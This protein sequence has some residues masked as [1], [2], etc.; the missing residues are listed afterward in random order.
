[1][2]PV[3]R[4]SALVLAGLVAAS[5]VAPAATPAATAAA[6]PAAVLADGETV[7]LPD[8]D[9]IARTRVLLEEARESATA[10]HP[11]VERVSG[12]NRY[13]TAAE[14]SRFWNEVVYVDDPL[15]RRLVVVASGEN[16]ADA[17]SG[18]AFAGALT[19][20]VLLT[21]K[22]S[23][24][25]ATRAAL[26][27]LAPHTIILLGG[28]GAVSDEVQAALADYAPG[29]DWVR[30]FGGP[31]RYVVSAS[32]ANSLGPSELAFVASGVNWPDGLAGGAAAAWEGAPLL[33][34]KPTGVPSSVMQSLRDEVR[35]RHIVLLGGPASV[36]DAV[37]RQL[38]TVAP[39]TRVA[40]RSRYET[41]AAL[42]QA[43]PTNYGAT[44]ASGLGWP[45]A[46]VGAA[47][48]GV[49][50]D[51]LLLLTPTGVP[52]S[53]A[54]TVTDLDLAWITALGGEASIPEPV[55]DQLRA[56]PVEVP[57]VP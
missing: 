7:P 36:D 46:L 15:A 14:L 45:D 13:E 10:G 28:P 24:P 25:G 27:R 53:T 56:L 50:G 4:L 21:R 8:A 38:E 40:G 34:T 12:A 6:T 19:S 26:E 20:P 29:R 5:P 37:L 11:L 49:L 9:Q 47:Y 32:L 23:L 51:K 2:S 43:S 3:R 30:R 42:A 41:A 22:D 17:L 31:D 18:G 55:L 54:Q 57:T 16:Y 48:A 35:P 52:A 39:V 33:V 44:V 1:M